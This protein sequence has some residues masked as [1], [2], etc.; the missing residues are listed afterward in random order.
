MSR[1]ESMQM[2]D[3]ACSIPLIPS[4]LDGLLQPADLETPP[5]I[6]RIPTM[7]TEITLPGLTPLEVAEVTPL[8]PIV[9]ITATVAPQAPTIIPEPGG[10]LLAGTGLGCLFVILAARRRGDERSA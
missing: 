4:Q 1:E 5:T 10:F 8:V 3:F 2:V 7:N 6:A 9:P